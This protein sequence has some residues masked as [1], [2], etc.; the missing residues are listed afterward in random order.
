MKKFTVIAFLLSVISMGCM[1]STSTPAGKDTT[2][3]VVTTD[4]LYE[5]SNITVKVYISS[6]KSVYVV[7]TKKDG[8]EYKQY[9]PKSIAA[10]I[11]KGNKKH[12][13]K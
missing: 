5:V 2:K 7:T 10:A 12:I 1:A 6:R 3:K 9:L 4:T 13:K 11:L 8:S